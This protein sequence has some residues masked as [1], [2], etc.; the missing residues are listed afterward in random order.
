LKKVFRISTLLLILALIV[1][2]SLFAFVLIVNRAQIYSNKTELLSENN[3]F[4]IETDHLYK[5][6]NFYK[7]IDEKELSVAG[8]YFDVLKIV[9][10]GK[11]KSRVYIYG[12]NIETGVTKTMKGH[13]LHKNTTGKKQQTGFADFL[14]LKTYTKHF[15]FNSI[16][17]AQDVIFGSESANTQEGHLKLLYQPP[18]A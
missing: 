12:D 10:L 9:D 11:G 14:K 18:T 6:D 4:D 16:L 15:C 2:N 17:C 7:W 5:D 8:N 1:V 3:Y 13:D